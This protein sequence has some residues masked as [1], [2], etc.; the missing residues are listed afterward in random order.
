MINMK[1]YQETYLCL[2]LITDW[3]PDLSLNCFTLTL[4]F[5]SEWV[6]GWQKQKS[7]QISNGVFVRMENVLLPMPRDKII[8]RRRFSRQDYLKPIECDA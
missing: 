8:F 3:T 7:G 4:T 6:D 1:K 5:T 2:I